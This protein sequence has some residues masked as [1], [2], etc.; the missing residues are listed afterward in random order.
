[1]K[2]LYVSCGSLYLIRQTPPFTERRNALMLSV[3]GTS[4][5]RH[6]GDE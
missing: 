5:C 1:M 6:E 4:H 3:T 2:G